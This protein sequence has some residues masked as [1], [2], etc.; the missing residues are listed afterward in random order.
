MASLFTKYFAPNLKVLHI[1]SNR[2]ENFGGSLDTREVVKSDWI[3]NNMEMFSCEIGN[4]PRPDITKEVLG[5]PVSK[6]VK[7]GILQESIELQR[8]VYSKLARFIK[9]RQLKLGY[10]FSLH[11]SKYK[12]ANAESK[13]AFI[14]TFARLTS[15][16]FEVPFV[17]DGSELESVELH[18]QAYPKLAMPTK[19]RVLT[20]DLP[21]CLE[22]LRERQFVNLLDMEV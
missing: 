15:T 5:E 17:K 3:C 21:S 2:M 22:G 14:T 7:S 12:G 16:E 4:V 11:V 9:S 13:R 20:L 18:L 8:R 6:Y 1:Q 19:L 10:W